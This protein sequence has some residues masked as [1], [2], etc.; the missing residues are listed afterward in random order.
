MKFV[1]ILLVMMM[2]TMGIPNL[3]LNMKG[4]DCLIDVNQI[5]KL[6]EER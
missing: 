1:V 2:C 6:L 5:S 3:F 4:Q